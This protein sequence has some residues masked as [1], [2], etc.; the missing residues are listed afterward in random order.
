MNV[1]GVGGVPGGA[2]GKIPDEEWQ[3]GPAEEEQSVAQRTTQAAA[4]VLS[5]PASEASS[6]G[7]SHIVSRHIRTTATQGSYLNPENVKDLVMAEF[8]GDKGR[9]HRAITYLVQKV[10]II[11][12]ERQEKL[13]ELNLLVAED[14]TP[15]ELTR[16]RS[17]DLSAKRM[18]K[19]EQVS[20]GGD[21]AQD[22]EL[23]EENI[24][25][26]ISDAKKIWN[27]VI[28]LCHRQPTRWEDKVQY[29][30]ASP[31][32]EVLKEIQPD[33]MGTVL[34]VANLGFCLAG[35]HILYVRSGRTLEPEQY[36]TKGHL[37][38]QATALAS[39]P[40]K[41]AGTEEDPIQRYS[42]TFLDD[43]IGKSLMT[44]IV[45]WWKGK[46]PES[47]REFLQVKL[48]NAADYG[49]T[50]HSHRVRDA[51]DKEVLI[52]EGAPIVTQKVFSSQANSL[53]NVI[54]AHEANLEGYR[55]LILGANKNLIKM[56]HELDLSQYTGVISAFCINP[57]D[58]GNISQ[59]ET[60]K[61]IIGRLYD[62]KSPNAAKMADLYSNL[63]A[64]LLLTTPGKNFRGMNPVALSLK[65]FLAENILAETAGFIRDIE[66]KSGN[67]RTATAAAILAAQND[68]KKKY[69]RP[70]LDLDN[71]DDL[72][73]FQ[74]LF[75]KNFV[76]V[77]LTNLQYSRGAKTLTSKEPKKPVVKVGGSPIFNFL[78]PV[79]SGGRKWVATNL[80]I[81]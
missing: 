81:H 4:R 15:P 41:R 72:K 76:Q 32:A 20:E 9:I 73:K 7:P 53:D 52:Y 68:F 44:R 50:L 37:A 39:D 21:A 51:Q 24:N 45:S 18:I 17:A 54:R 59:L 79:G 78:A 31:S 75:G 19:K 22:V 13:E 33:W 63:D 11:G 46:A 60:L 64:M 36:E 70:F 10:P 26:E 58:K 77:A 80:D 74:D 40:T 55:S 57:L 5:Q 71:G 29:Q 69:G 14:R 3:I 49:R 8:D 12:A 2:S 67:D 43:A 47:E 1:S 65:S 23:E 62:E 27:Y 34:D 38:A 35:N 56:L 42:T 61:N 28:G 66:C 6:A 25:D 48:N 30:A 16:Q